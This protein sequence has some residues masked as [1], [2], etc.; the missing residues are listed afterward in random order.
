MAMARADSAWRAREERELA[1]RAAGGDRFA[2]DIL[3]DRYFARVAWHFRDLP[4]LRAQAAI[5][6]ALEQIFAG[7]TCA[8]PFAERAYRIARASGRSR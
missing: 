5:W 8:A 7:L 4:E 6:E 2:F 3:Y 1:R